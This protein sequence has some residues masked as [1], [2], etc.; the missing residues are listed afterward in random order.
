MTTKEYS[1]SRARTAPRYPHP[2]GSTA[3]GSNVAYRLGKLKDLGLL[4]GVWLDCGCAD[5]GYTEALVA[6]GAEKA[7]GVDPVQSRIDEAI[8]RKL[9][10][11]FHETGIDGTGSMLVDSSFETERGVVSWQ[12]GGRRSRWR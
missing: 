1:L 6:W 5:G 7:V 2:G 8:A 3:A 9:D 10:D 12:D 4:H 11:R